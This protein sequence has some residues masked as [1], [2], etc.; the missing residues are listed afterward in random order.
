[1]KAFGKLSFIYLCIYFVQVYKT[2]LY[3]VFKQLSLYL[4]FHFLTQGI[5]S[6]CLKFEGCFN[7]V[8]SWLKPNV[9][10]D[11]ATK[12][13]YASLAEFLFFGWERIVQFSKVF[14]FLMIAE[15]YTARFEIWHKI[16]QINFDFKIIYIFSIHLFQYFSQYSLYCCSGIF[17]C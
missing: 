3:S 13:R 17:Q 16:L 15:V 8:F 6:Q 1:M 10:F 11:V 7:G 9:I 4:L 12:V 5:L 14:L 2:N